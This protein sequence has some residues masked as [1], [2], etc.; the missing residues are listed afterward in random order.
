MFATLL[1]I[2][3]FAAPVFQGVAATDFTTGTYSLTECEPA[4]FS[5]TATTPPYDV[6][7]V[8]ASDPCGEV[9]QVADLGQHNVTSITW[10]VDLASTTKPLMLS[11]QDSTADENEAWSGAMQIAAGTSTSCLNNAAASSSAAAVSP[12]ETTLEATE[13]VGAAGAA[14]TTGSTDG[15]S[16][17]LGASSGGSSGAITLRMNP[18][19][20]LCAVFAVALVL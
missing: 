3:L 4:H 11:I 10:T 15:A 5:W 19:M 16:G 2:A 8:Y 18:I 1:T 7:L 9:V 12:T 17:A 14:V 6:V 20:A 13:T